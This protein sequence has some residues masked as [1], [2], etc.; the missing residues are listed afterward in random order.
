[1]WLDHRYN[2]VMSNGNQNSRPEDCFVY[3][4][5]YTHGDSKG[6]YTCRLDMS[7]GELQQVGVATEADN[8]SYLAIDAERNRLYAET[9]KNRGLTGKG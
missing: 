1:M 8:P 9:T 4:G 5:T 3:V 7:S 2:I 6:I